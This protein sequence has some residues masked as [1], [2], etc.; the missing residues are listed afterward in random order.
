MKKEGWT[1][2]H[3]AKYLRAE[4]DVK[5]KADELMKVMKDKFK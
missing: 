3:L 4:K 1:Y 2:E 5:V